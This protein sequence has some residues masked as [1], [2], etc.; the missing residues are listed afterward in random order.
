MEC[1]SVFI[2]SEIFSPCWCTAVSLK[3]FLRYI[4][5]STCFFHQTFVL[6]LFSLLPLFWLSQEELP[7]SSAS[8]LLWATPTPFRKLFDREEEKFLSPFWVPHTLPI[9]LAPILNEIEDFI[10]SLQHMK[11]QAVP[12]APSIQGVLQQ[13]CQKQY[14]RASKWTSAGTDCSINFDST[15]PQM[16]AVQCP[17]LGED[18]PVAKCYM[19]YNHYDR[20]WIC[21]NS[22][23]TLVL[24]QICHT[25]SQL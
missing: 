5:N 25:V 8:L 20:K 24:L 12:F 14:S 6:S 13:Y 16:Q 22:F 9:H 19:Q 23:E 3:Y 17:A 18:C 4:L 21:L 15:F 7:F 1:T 2:I 11:I 10:S